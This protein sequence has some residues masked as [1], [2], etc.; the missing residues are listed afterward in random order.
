M[1]AELPLENAGKNIENLPE[2][3]QLVI[4]T[5]LPMKDLYSCAR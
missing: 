1:A 5:Y 4:F 2:N 3:I